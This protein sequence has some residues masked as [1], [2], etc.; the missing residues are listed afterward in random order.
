MGT[1]SGLE[2]LDRRF[3]IPGIASVGEGNGAMP[4]VQI[5]SSFCEAEMYLHG[6]QVTSWKPAGSDEVLFLSGNRGG[7]MVRQSEVGFLSV[8]PGFAPRPMIPRLRHTGSRA[9]DVAARI[10]S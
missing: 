7:W 10:D 6:A 3:G 4:R 9:Q 5:T 8:S 2:D 1:L